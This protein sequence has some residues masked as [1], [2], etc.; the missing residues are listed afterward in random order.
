MPS[1]MA[2]LVHCLQTSSGGGFATE[3]RAPTLWRWLRWPAQLDGYDVRAAAAAA[4]ASSSDGGGGGG[5]AA[6]RRGGHGD[7]G[8][9]GES[10]SSSETMLAAA[11]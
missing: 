2:E 10:R 1:S 4:A 6:R 3:P 5:A 9:G 8:G 7:G 11:P